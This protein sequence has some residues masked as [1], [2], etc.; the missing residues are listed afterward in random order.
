VATCPGAL[1]AEGLRPNTSLCVSLLDSHVKQYGNDAR[2]PPIEKPCDPSFRSWSR[3]VLK[4]IDNAVVEVGAT[5]VTIE[6]GP[7][8]EI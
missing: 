8:I 4:V 6:L 3:R 5:E 2:C 7:T 1:A